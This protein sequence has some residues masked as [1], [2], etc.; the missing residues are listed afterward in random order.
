LCSRPE[1]TDEMA[2]KRPSTQFVTPHALAQHW[3]RRS[4]APSVFT[5]FVRS[6]EGEQTPDADLF[7]DAWHGLRALLVS[8]MKRRG[9]WQSP[10]RYLGVCGWERWDAEEPQADPWERTSAL[11]ELVADGYAFIFVDRLPGLKRQLAEKPDIDGLVLLDVRHFLLERQKAHDPLGFRIFELLQEAVTGAVA[12]GDLHV[13][14]GDRRVRNDTLLAFAPTVELPSPL[15]PLEDVA[16]RWNDELLPALVTARSRR[17]AAV[18]RELRRRLLE[19]PRQGIAAFRFRDLLD[20]LKSDARLRWA[21]LFGEGEEPG[22]GAQARIA[23]SRPAVAALESAVESRQSF[24]HL[25]HC[26]AAAIPCVETDSRTREQLSALWQYLRR[27]NERGEEPDPEAAGET[28]PSFRELSRHL[29]I[30]RQRFPALFAT[31][32]QLVS[33]CRTGGRVRGTAAG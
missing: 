11:G 2:N 26:V 1:E 30:P 6:L 17:Q 33:R 25:T 28:H 15:P 3:P 24:E 14:G 7:H 4:S 16:M 20:P 27:R 12:Q 13:L 21:A 22:D 10:P 23:G 5:A 29:G 32:R 9:V 18:V 19:L 8:E 31:L